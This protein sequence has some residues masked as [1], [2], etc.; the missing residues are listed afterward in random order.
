MFKFKYQ[1]ST[2]E[3]WHKDMESQIPI[4]LK[5]NTFKLKSEFGTGGAQYFELQ[6][7][8]W[9]EEMDFNLK[10]HLDVEVL[11][12]PTNDAFFINFWLTNAQVK[13]LFSEDE[14]VLD[15]K[16][17]NVSVVL[18][19]SATNSFYALPKNQQVKLV[20]IW[21]TR[22]WLLENAVGTKNRRFRSLFEGDAPLYLTESLDYRF[23]YIL[24]QID[25]KNSSKLNLL[26]STLQLLNFFFKNLEKQNV[27]NLAT[28]NIHN[29]DLKRM[30]Y[31]KEYVHANPLEDN[32]LDDMAEI[33]GMSLSKFKRLFK[34]VFGTTPYKYCMEHK[35]NLA[36]EMLKKENY[37]VSQTGFMIGYS[38]LSQFSKAFKNK[39][40]QLPSQVRL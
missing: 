28:L 8:L 40:G 14:K 3:N 10:D 9:I 36:M 23:K 19:S 13:Q 25:F 24:E 16:Y 35:L 11:R 27:N 39:F 38:N 22:E 1:I 21:M 32:S 4:V 2:P 17:D 7:G 5:E 6:P 15:F 34:K 18:L 12:K 30:L 20:M 31:V 29:S 33:A 37:S 26:S